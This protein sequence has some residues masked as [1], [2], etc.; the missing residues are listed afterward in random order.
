MNRDTPTVESSRRRAREL[1]DAIS[2]LMSSYAQYPEYAA[3]LS[4]PY[5]EEL[6]HERARVDEVLGIPQLAAAD[7]VMHIRTREA[8]AG[9]PRASV[10]VDAISNL[11]TAL[12]GI[13]I[14]L[15]GQ[16][17][18]GPGRLPEQLRRATDF[19]IVGLAAGS[20]KI[21]IAFESRTR[22]TQLTDIKEE[23]SLTSDVRSA[24]QL[25]WST[26]A[27]LTTGSGEV[28]A[29]IP[30]ERTRTTV[31]RELSRLSPSPRG[32]VSSITLE[33]VPA[34]VEGPAT[35]TAETGKRALKIL[36]PGSDSEPFD[37]V[38]TL[39]AI[40]V[41]RDKRKHLFVLRG[42]PAGRPEVEGDFQETLRFAVM[43]AVDKEHQVRVRGVLERPK[44][45][46]GKAVVHI[47]SLEMA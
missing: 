21:G 33:G 15:R 22:Q 20:V 9:A 8:T 17:R 6:F 24:T 41:D 16:Y 45:R 38:G 3:E 13:T 31:L 7:A 23:G 1:E 11:R 10:V 42:R 4:A 29:H 32:K 40:E 25:L 18:A 2:Y 12:I 14:S 47:D 5:V 27:I 35:L 34:M 26:A 39:R 46:G 44:G 30:N 43:Q 19:R 36:Y 28:S 37:D